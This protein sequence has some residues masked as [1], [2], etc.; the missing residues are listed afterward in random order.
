MKAKNRRFTQRELELD[1]VRKVVVWSGR[2]PRELT[3]AYKAFSFVREG[4]GR[5][6]QDATCP[7]DLEQEDPLQGVLFPFT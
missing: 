3:R 5:L 6:D 7:G 1:D 4:M 2:S